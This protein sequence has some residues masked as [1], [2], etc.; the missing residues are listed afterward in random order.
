MSAPTVFLSAAT[1]DLKPW[2]DLLAKAF[3]A[4]QFR[5]LVQDDSLGAPVGKVRGLLATAIEESDCVIHLAGQGYGSHATDP[6]PDHPGFRCSWTQF[7]YYYPHQ[8]PTPIPVIGFVCGPALSVM[9]KPEEGDDDDDVALKIRL[10]QAHCARVISGKFDD[11]PWDHPKAR[12]VNAKTAETIEDLL[13]RVSEQIGT[14]Q[15]HHNACALAQTELLSLRRSNLHQLPPVKAHFTGRETDLA[16]LRGL[17]DSTSGGAAVITGL[18]GMGG[19]G[20]SELAKVLARE[21]AGRFPDAQ[22]WLDGF[23]T[24]TEPPPPAPGNLIETVIRAFHPQAGPLPEDLPT[25]QALYHQTLKGKRALIVLDNAADAAQAGPLVPPAGCG[26]IVSSRREFMIAGRKPHH[27]GR[28]PETEAVELLRGICEDLTE[29][30]AAAVAAKCAGLPL[31][32]RLAGAHLALDGASPAAVKRYLDALAG[33]RLATLAADA[34]DAGEVTIQETLRLSVDPLPAAERAAWLRLGVFTGDWDADAARAVAGDAAD[35]GLLSRLARRNLLERVEKTATAAGGDSGERHRLHDLAADYARERLAKEEGEAARDAAYLAHA[36][37]Y[38]AVGR[39]TSELYLAGDVLAGLALFDRERVQ[40]EAAFAWLTARPGGDEESESDRVADETLLAL[41]DGVAYTGQEL[42]FHPR[43]RI[44]WLEA[45][46][47]AA[48]RL[49]HRQMEGAALGNLGLAHAGLGD[50]RRAFGYYEQ[51]LAIVR[52]IGDR[53]GE[54]NAL[55]SLGTAHSDLG[56]ARRAL[57]YYEQ[58]LALHREIGDR[59]GEGNALGNLGNAHLQLGDARRAIEYYEQ[60]LVIDRE[61]G[62]RRGEGAD[63]GNL[64]NAHLELGDARRAIGY[65]EQQ[66]EIVRE[67]GDRRGEGAAL[68]NL[69]SA[70]LQLGDARRAIGHYEQQLEIV[71]EIGDRRGEGIALTGLGNAHLHLGDARRA[72]GYYE[73]ALVIDREIGDR[74]GEG[75]ALWNAALAHES[76]GERAAALARAET[77]LAIFEA[78]EDPDVE[79]VRARVE[80]WRRGRLGDWELTR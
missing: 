77:A 33:G 49:G 19:I 39:K 6:F 59:R 35:P 12:T 5:V 29:A 31:A 78:I 43:Q 22:L 53:R 40:I 28:L 73:Q 9:S 67:I 36:G 63:L 23:G 70:H 54:G 65:Y 69:G 61:I 38:A 50:A 10:Q 1:I 18:G 71:R 45:Q 64:G 21:W 13:V 44:A 3:R 74:R 80:T 60:A 72:I 42:R 47:A 26:Y 20:K 56:D 55:G 30:D 41:V 46:A 68:G 34:A 16:A 2:R 4:A 76:L 79:R 52:E 51:Y 57:G 32:L 14:L 24:R 75:I 7:E 62:D 25:L 58:C 11:T 27:V 17:A 66:L 15:R 8:L 48:R 37:H